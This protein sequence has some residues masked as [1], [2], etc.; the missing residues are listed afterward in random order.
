VDVDLESLGH[1]GEL[2]GGLALIASLLYVAVQIRQNTAS[3]RLQVEQAIKRDQIEMR[4]SI[5]ENPELGDLLVKAIAD[6][7]SLSP[8]ERVRANMIIANVIEHLQ[9]IFLLRHEGLVH[10]ESQEAVLRGY[11]ALKPYRQWWNLGREILQPEFVD[12]VERH[13]LPAAASATRM[14][15]MP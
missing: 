1:L 8:A 15:W 14:H 3:V 2:I 5:I 12:H 9:R 13:I 10:W 4:R 6:F 7:D 11:L